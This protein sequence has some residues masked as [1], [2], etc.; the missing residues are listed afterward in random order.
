MI[1]L[2]KS[3]A[4]NAPVSELETESCLLAQYYYSHIQKFSF[5]T[6]NNNN[7]VKIN[8][9]LAEAYALYFVLVDGRFTQADPPVIT[10]ITQL[11]NQ[12][13]ISQ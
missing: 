9:N 1:D 11:Q 2:L 3:V 5:F 6:P 12:I 4:E 7:E 13:Y 10:F 8:L